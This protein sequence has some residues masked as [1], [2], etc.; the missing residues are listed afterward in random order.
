MANFVNQAVG[1]NAIQ[2]TDRIRGGARITYQAPSVSVDNTKVNQMNNFADNLSRFAQMGADAFQKYDNKQKMSAD[3]RSNEIIRKMS[4]EEIRAATNSGTLLYKDD[5]YAMKALRE[6]TGRNAAFQ[7]DDDISTKIRNG[8]FKSRKEMEQYRHD[9]LNKAVATFADQYGINTTD[10]DY[11]RGFNADITQR[12][13]SLYGAHDQFLSERAK[14]G[15]LQQSKVELDGLLSD[16]QVLRSPDAGAGFAAYINSNQKTGA[17]PSD[18]QTAAVIKSSLSDAMNREGGRSFLDSVE[19]QKVTLNGVTQTYRQFVGEEQWT[20]MQ[21][22]ASASEYDLNSK[23]TESL[24]LGVATAL[25]QADASAGMEMLQQL[26]AANNQYQSGDEMTPQRQMLISAEAQM[27]E[28]VK[29]ERDATLKATEKRQQDDQKFLVMDAQYN[30]R[31]N[32][33]YVATDYKN[34]PSN[35]TTGEFSYSDSVNFANRKLLQIDAMGIP[36]EQKDAMK[37]KYLQADSDNGPFRAAFGTQVGDAQKEWTAA[38]INGKLPEDA[39]ALKGL[40]QVMQQDPSLIAALYPD[41]ADLFN[42]MDLMD[43]M[44]VDPQVLIDAE[45]QAKSQSQDMRKQADLDYA[46]AKNDSKYP[47][48]ARVPASMDKAMRA[49][50]DSTLF[51]TGNRDMARQQASKFVKENTVTFKGDDIDGDVIGVLPRNLLR[52]TD[53]PASYKQGQDILDAAAK[54]VAANTPWITNKQLTISQTGKSIYLMD[55]TGTVRLRYDQELLRKVYAD[56]QAKLDEQKRNEA[57]K[58]ANERAPIAQVGKAR[59]E[60]ARRVRE[61]KQKVPKYIYGRKDD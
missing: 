55:T 11:Q 49:V 54:Q 42:K 16:P 10:E 19:K 4:P 25:N 37:L 6:K 3:E 59:E 14:Q 26:K 33:E 31:L 39:S 58:K 48:M 47:E 53:D 23:R 60:A 61:N 34:M 12:N 43:N 28:R 24:Q 5:P 9:E 41:Q 40:R 52:V 21:A 35:E 38:V 29:R 17:L 27:V 1:L 20:N 13:I 32:G 2:G 30:K 46:D 44:G 56:Q 8:E 36:Q 51:A 50:Y 15:N 18:E 7:V 22:K 57:L 45:R